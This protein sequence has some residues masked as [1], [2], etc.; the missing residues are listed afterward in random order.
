MN[1]GRDV[2]VQDEVELAGE[3][4][5]EIA[6][7]FHTA[8]EVAITD[9]GRQA[10]LRQGGRTLYA[11]LLSPSDGR[12]ET[13]SANPPPPQAQQPDVK[14]L[15]VRVRQAGRAVTIAVLLSTR[16]RSEAMILP[17]DA[18]VKAAP[19]TKDSR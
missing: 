16:E 12:F 17:L 5:H 4:E 6:W 18:W 1:D 3:Q 8:A 9:D 11:S 14:N 10:T 19:I 2:L 13:I 15:V 7:N